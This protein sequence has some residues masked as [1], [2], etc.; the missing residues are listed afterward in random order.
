MWVEE[1]NQNCRQGEVRDHE[2]ETIRGYRKVYVWRLQRV[3][4]KS[5]NTSEMEVGNQGSTVNIEQ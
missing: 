4:G 5:S 2:S 1:E 3:N